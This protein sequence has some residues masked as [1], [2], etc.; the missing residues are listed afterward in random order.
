MDFVQLAEQFLDADRDDPRLGRFLTCHVGHA[1]DDGI[2]WDAAS[3]GVV[4]ALL[5]AGLRKGLFDGALVTQMSPE[6][7][8]QPM[9][10]LAT[11]EQEIKEATGSK[12]CPVAANMRLRQILDSEGRFA[13]VGLPCHMHGLRMAQARIPK[14][15]KKVAV[16]ISLFCGLNMSPLG[17]R[18]ALN[19][20]QVP[21][22]EV[23]E[24]RYRGEGWPGAL[25]VQLRDGQTYREHLY[26]Y[27]DES[28]SAYEMYRCTQ[29][30]DAFGELA[31]ISCG[32]AWLPEYTANDDRGTSVVIVRDTR[33]QNLL[34]SSSPALELAPLDA[35]RAAASQR[36]ALTSKKDWL[37]AK[38]A[39]ARLAG[40]E[41]PTYQQDLPAPTWKGY[42]ASGGQIVTRF[43]NRQWCRMRGLHR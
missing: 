42:V 13:V 39:L 11:T 36:S 23:T 14:L 4:T 5:I 27:F 9:P 25:Q 2:R 30:S 21:I 28:F 40:K 41:T 12:Y 15:R 18:V 24:L 6:S 43:L 34:A 29:C 31:D 17:T 33:G 32:D 7:P 16:C 20:R 26:S 19:R 38:V 10:I 22:D 8:L 35:D 1:S 37:R 3:G